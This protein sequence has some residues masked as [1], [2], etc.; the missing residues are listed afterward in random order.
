MMSPQRPIY[1]DY[2]ATTPIDPAVKSAMLPWLQNHFGNPSSVHVYGKVV[3]QAVELARQQLANLIGSDPSEIV[4]TGSGTEASNLAIKGSI[5]P[6]LL[7]LSPRRSSQL[8][9]IHSAIEHPA[10]IKPCQWLA[11]FGCHIEVIPVDQFGILNLDKLRSA[12]QRLTLLVSIMHSNNEVGTLQHVREIACMAHQAGAL[13]HVDA[14]QSL[15]KV[16]INVREFD[17]DLMTIAGHKLYAPKGVGALFV[18]K[19]IQLE[20]VIH[21][22]GQEAGR[23]AGTENVPYIVGLGQAAEIARQ[24]LPSATQHLQQLRDRLWNGLKERLEDIVQLNGHANERLPNTLNISVKGWFGSEL[25][26]ACPSIA[27]STGSACHEGQVSISPVLAAMGI[28]SERAQGAVRLSV[29]RFTTEAEIDQ[30]VDAIS[31]VVM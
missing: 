21:G 24:S 28:D 5:W 13:I 17:I 22:A 31:Q 4:F 19:G 26:T 29:G 18:R 15:G 14:A 11:K 3:H 10:T 16:S 9:V 23:R 6:R 27:A 25:L 2:N 8:Q 1:L 7:E 12:L 30:A 20:S